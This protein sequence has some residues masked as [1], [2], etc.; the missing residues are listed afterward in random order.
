[1]K[2][3][4]TGKGLTGLLLTTILA[5]LAGLAA[6]F[7]QRGSSA[8]AGTV[9]IE[10]E[11]SRVVLDGEKFFTVGMY[12]T[13]WAGT[14]E[15]LYADLEIIAAGGFNV[16]HPA[17]DLQ[18]GPFLDRAEEL[19]LR[20]IVEINEPEG[21][22]AMIEAFRDRPVIM[23]WSV[24][25][26]FNSFTRPRE[27]EEVAELNRVARAIAPDQLTYISGVTRNMEQYL[28]LSDIMAI[29]TYSIPSDPLD[30]TYDLLTFALNTSA[31]VEETIFANLQTYAAPGQR[32]P[33]GEEVRNITYQALIT[34]VDGLL[35]YAYFDSVWNLADYPELWLSIVQT[36]G[37]VRQL[38]PILLEGELMQ[39]PSGYEGVYVGQW[40]YN[41]QRYVVIINTTQAV[42]DNLVLPLTA[43]SL[44]PLF[45]SRPAGFALQNGTLTGTLAPAGVDVYILQ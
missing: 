43:R 27:P 31:P 6:L 44:S 7:W 4:G 35:Y 22:A 8:P 40:T 23:G 19:G 5:A 12:H 25:D 30:T 45:P 33:T 42:Q 37:E 38:I 28:G 11:A 16:M 21:P 3:S 32:P 2:R 17:L 39:I 29:Q 18:D 26:D 9:I 20:L 36:V 41:E 15:Q 13:S 14:R 24:V 1:M 34:G 10:R